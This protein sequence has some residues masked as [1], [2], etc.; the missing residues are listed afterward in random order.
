[1]AANAIRF[2]RATV[3][4]GIACGLFAISSLPG[5][6]SELSPKF[7]ECIAEARSA[8][9]SRTCLVGELDRQDVRLNMVYHDAM[10][11]LSPSAQKHLREAQ[12]AWIKFRDTKCEPEDGVDKV[13]EIWDYPLC[14]AIETKL[15]ADE[16]SKIRR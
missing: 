15:R 7:D 1:M 9:Q 13:A 12:R 10:A 2:A 4:L 3:A 6:T 14:I 16:L 5:R 11:R 8:S